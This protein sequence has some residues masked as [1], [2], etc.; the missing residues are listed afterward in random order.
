MKNLRLLLLLISLSTFSQDKNSIDL[1][2]INLCELS[3]ADLHLEDPNLQEVKLE[4][5]DLCADGFVE[6]AQF[7]N[8][9]G[10]ITNNYPGVIFQ[11]YQTNNDLIAKIH[12]TT[13]FKGY[14]EIRNN[15]YECRTF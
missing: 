6:D 1:S 4:E 15:K 13:E 7:E 2:E 14:L 12:L 3:I 8:R 10:Y 9:K 11:K 5:M